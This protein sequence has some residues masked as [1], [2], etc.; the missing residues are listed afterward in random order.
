M[1]DTLLPWILFNALIVALLAVDLG[2]FH[3][4]AHVVSTREAATWSAIWIALALLFNAGVFFFSGSERGVEF[5]TGYLIEKSL[6]GT[7]SG[8]SASARRVKTSTWWP[9]SASSRASS[10]T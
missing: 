1:M 5:L 9:R 2:I 4:N 7:V 3:R 6:S 10:R 8:A